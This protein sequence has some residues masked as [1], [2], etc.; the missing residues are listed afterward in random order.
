MVL[1]FAIILAL[2]AVSLAALIYKAHRNTHQLNVTKIRLGERNAAS[3]RTLSVLHISDMHLEHISISPE[4]LYET[5]KEERIDLIALTGDFLD[6]VRTIPKLAPYLQAMSKLAPKFG[7]YAVYG[8]HDYALKGEAFDNLNHVLERYGCKTMR[9]DADTIEVDGI[10]VNIIG[11]DDFCTRRSNPAAAYRGMESGYNLVLTHDPNLVLYMKDYHYDYLLA[12]HFHGGQIYWPKPFHLAKMGKLA[13]M[14]VV[15]GLHT[16][17]GKPF[18]ISEGLG[19]TGI[20]I[21]LGSRPEITVHEI[22]L[23]D[24]R[25]DK[26]TAV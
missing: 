19:Q 1:F 12:G 7:M 15:K 3:R 11:I 5:L 4:Q 20:N 10:K 9:N 22:V 17:D 16:H 21:R 6:R 18:Y 26:K 25:A 14:N 13:R 23:P 24:A 2:P 8:N